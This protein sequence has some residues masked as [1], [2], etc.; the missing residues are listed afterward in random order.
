M[1]LSR[2]DYR[3]S[4]GVESGWDAGAFVQALCGAVGLH[5]AHVDVALDDALDNERAEVDVEF[6]DRDISGDLKAF[7]DGH[8]AENPARSWELEF[9]DYCG[10]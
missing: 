6:E 7:L 5:F 3:F 10:E 2:V 8:V 1:G 4:M 9:N